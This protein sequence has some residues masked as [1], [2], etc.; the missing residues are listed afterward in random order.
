[1]GGMNWATT[2]AGGINNGPNGG[3]SLAE[4]QAEEEEQERKRQER[5]RQQKRERQKEMGLAQ[6]SVWGSAS[7]NLSWANKAATIGVVTATSNSTNP[8]TPQA[9]SKQNHQGPASSNILP[10]SSAPWSS[11]VNPSSGGGG[12]WDDDGTPPPGLNSSNTNQSH[13]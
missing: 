2:A 11:A 8:T 9:K 1:M 10:S 4:I 5:E 12:F 3:K 13:R 7:S 6:A